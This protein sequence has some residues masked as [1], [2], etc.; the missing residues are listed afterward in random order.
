MA[1][2]APDGRRAY[3]VFDARAAGGDT[4]GATVM[5]AFDAAS[6]GKAKRA[7]HS[8]YHDQPYVL[9]GVTFNSGHAVQD[10]APLKKHR[11]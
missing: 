7:A 3:L 4:D 2:I 5:Y 6:D 9:Y 1:E 11:C 8:M 10:E